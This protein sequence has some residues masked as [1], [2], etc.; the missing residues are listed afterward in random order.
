VLTASGYVTPR[1]R[2][3]VAAKITGRVVEMLVEEG[4]KVEKDQVLARLDDAEA[5]AALNTAKSQ[6]D[7]VTAALTEL[8]VD[9]ANAQ[10]DLDRAL[11]LEKKGIGTRQDLDHAQ[12]AADALKARLQLT[13]QQVRAAEALVAQAEQDLKNCTVRAPFAGVAVSKDAQVGE[14]VSP[15]SAGGGFTRTGIS[16]VV[17]MASLEVEVD[18]NESYLSRVHDGQLADA[19]LDAY[20]DWHIAAHVRTIIPTA[21]RQKATVKV[22]IAFDALD[23]RILPDMGVKVSFLQPSESGDKKAR[24]L[25]PLAALMESEGQQV[26]WVVKGGVIERHAVRAGRVIGKDVEILS[27]ADAGD[28]VVVSALKPLKSGLK[29][30]IKK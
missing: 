9:L 23:P 27:G 2:A 3:T 11:D 12:A 25:V 29:A 13:A 26:V 17:N 15:V 20:P 6:K 10:R 8:N 16:T 18:V 30:E 19:T 14:M 24:C 7:V 21:D 28:T 22:R 1:E 4:M 5:R